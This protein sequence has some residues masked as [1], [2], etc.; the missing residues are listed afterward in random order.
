MGVVVLA[1]LVGG[2]F[3]LQPKQESMPKNA[4]K[5]D[6]GMQVDDT[7]TMEEPVELK[8]IV[9][10]ASETEDFSTL[11]TAV[12]EAGLVETLSSEG[13]FTVFAPT[14]AAFDKLPAG[15]LDAVLADKEKLASI[16]TYHVVE[17]AV[18]SDKVVEMDSALTVQG[19]SVKISMKDGD[20][21]VNDAK[22]VTVDIK[23]SNGVIHV[24]DTVLLPK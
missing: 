3:L 2:Y 16:L 24:I 18:T 19:Q 14:N 4:E 5:A 21:Y 13:P 23:A 8:S 6:T 7:T 10:I 22:I 1:V 17:G 11:V 20:V 9:D 12:T 15:T